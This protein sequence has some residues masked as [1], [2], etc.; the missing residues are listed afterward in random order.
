MYAIIQVHHYTGV[1]LP[2]RPRPPRNRGDVSALARGCAGGTSKAGGTC[3]V[4]GGSREKPLLAPRLRPFGRL[5]GVIYRA[6]DWKPV[7]AAL[8]AIAGES[9]KTPRKMGGDLSKLDILPEHWPLLVA[10]I[11]ER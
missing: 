3:P 8:E 9:A 2:C 7:R 10:E 5:L 4:E 1:L 11:G 6:E